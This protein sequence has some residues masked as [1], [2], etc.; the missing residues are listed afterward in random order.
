[1]GRT[2]RIVVPCALGLLAAFLVSC[3]SSSSDKKLI[4]STDAAAIN[5][6]VDAASSA[7]GDGRC[8]RAD[9]AVTRAETHV[10]QLPASVD[11]RLKA[12]LQQGLQRLRAAAATEC[13]QNQ[14]DT[15]TTETTPSTETTDTTPTETQPTETQNTETQN[16]ETQNT[17]TQN[18]ETQNTDT[19]GGN[20]NGNGNGGGNGDGNGGDSS[21][22]TQAP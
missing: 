10:Q 5:Q 9:A 18:T 2:L 19:S 11:S 7:S 14:Q 22:G 1:M 17:E 20:G 12:D 13:A 16:T 4:P 8:E 3:G 15:T 6:N 21:G